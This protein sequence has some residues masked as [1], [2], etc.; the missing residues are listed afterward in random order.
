MVY[1]AFEYVVSFRGGCLRRTRWIR[2]SCV[3]MCCEVRS[4][5]VACHPLA[6][7]A[8]VGFD[9]NGYMRCGF[10]RGFFAAK[11]RAGLP[12]YPTGCLIEF[13]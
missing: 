2:G 4:G 13:S 1:L 8:V 6:K 10:N 5:G 3:R 12:L 9:A 7:G 11:V